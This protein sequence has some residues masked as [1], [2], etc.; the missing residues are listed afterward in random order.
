MDL[1]NTSVIVFCIPVVHLF[2]SKTLQEGTFTLHALQMKNRDTEMLSDL[3]DVMQLVD[4][5]D[6]FW[7][8]AGA[9]QSA[10]P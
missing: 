8:Q 10:S 7:T 6:G 3:P 2:L 4:G 1:V 9:D 5:R